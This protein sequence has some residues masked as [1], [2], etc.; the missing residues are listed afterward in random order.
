MDLRYCLLLAI[1]ISHLSKGQND[2]SDLETWE[3]SGSAD[4][5]QFD[6][7]QWVLWKNEPLQMNSAS[8]D[9]LILLPGVSSIMAHQMIEYRSRVKEIKSP[10][11]LLELPAWTIRQVKGIIPLV[12]FEANK[13]HHDRPRRYWKHELILR[14]KFGNDQIFFRNLAPHEG[15]LGYGYLLYRGRFSDLFRWGVSTEKDP[16]ERLSKGLESP[17]HRSGFIQWNPNYTIKQFVLERIWIGSIRLSWGRGLI[18]REGFRGSLGPQIKSSGTILARGHASSAETG[19]QNG[20]L[21]QGRLGLV[22]WGVWKSRTPRHIK[23][24]TLEG[25]FTTA[26]TDGLFTSS[27]KTKWW[28]SSH[29]ERTGIYVLGSFRHWA[30]GGLFEK[31]KWESRVPTKPI[32]TEQTRK[33]IQITRRWSRL[34]GSF[35]W[36]WIGDREKLEFQ[37]LWV[38]DDQWK[39]RLTFHRTPYREMLSDPRFMF[40]IGPQGQEFMRFE[41]WWNP[42][43]RMRLYWTANREW[44]NSFWAGRIEYGLSEQLTSQIDFRVRKERVDGRLQFR[45]SW[46]RLK[47]TV[48]NQWNQS[49]G[50]LGALTYLDIQWKKSSHSR[51]YLRWTSYSSSDFDHRLYVYENDLLYTFSVPSFHGKGQR[52][53]FMWTGLF[54]R[55]QFWVKTIFHEGWEVRLQYRLKW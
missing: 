53:Y 22:D 32:I 40:E 43:P 46:P 23:I 39:L 3:S 42:L 38:P 1:F 14:T 52:M 34:K 37:T 7:E 12:S 47:V 45:K 17:I 21:T 26:Y 13:V 33:S 27:E 36:G 30:V 9:D 11:E 50:G 20:I 16:G 10:Y 8:M 6:Q 19:Y 48:R 44:E 28:N 18:N 31:R 2:L 41:Q 4:Q 51:F 54:D 29:E 15:D 55:H 49:K 25:Q 5:I 24:D 35:E